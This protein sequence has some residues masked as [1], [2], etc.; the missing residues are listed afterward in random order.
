MNLSRSQVNQTGAEAITMHYCPDA[1]TAATLAL[2]AMDAVGGHPENLM[3][4]GVSKTFAALLVCIRHAFKAGAAAALE[5]AG[6]DYQ[7]IDPI[8]RAALQ[9]DPEA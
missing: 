6:A 4:P 7:N 9:A 3:P 2:D 5:E 8:L 1:A